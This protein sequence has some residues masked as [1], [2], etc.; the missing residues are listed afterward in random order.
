MALKRDKVKDDHLNLLNFI[1]VT[2]Y[3]TN[4]TFSILPLIDEPQTF[5]SLPFIW[6]KSS[7]HQNYVYKKHAIPKASQIADK[8]QN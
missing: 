7:N 6:H 3:S 8:L 2:K 5:I 4:C 1:Q